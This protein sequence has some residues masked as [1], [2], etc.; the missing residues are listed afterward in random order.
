MQLVDRVEFGAQSDDFSLQAFESIVAVLQIGSGHQGVC[1]EGIFLL[2]ELHDLGK[3]R[4]VFM[5]E[6]FALLV[7]AIDF[8]D[9]PLT[10]ASLWM[11]H[12]EHMLNF[13]KLFHQTVVILI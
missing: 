2:T 9:H 5:A 10:E 13:E 6:V 4:G 11:L 8:V 12:P 7:D 3:L 1:L